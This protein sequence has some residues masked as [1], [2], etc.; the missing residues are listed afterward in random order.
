MLPCSSLLSEWQLKEGSVIDL[1]CIM[2][3]SAKTNKVS[4]TNRLK[5]PVY[6]A[7]NIF[8]EQMSFMLHSGA[9]LNKAVCLQQFSAQHLENF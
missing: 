1:F 7:V 8:Q 2:L 5:K 9:W 3:H 6:P 4:T